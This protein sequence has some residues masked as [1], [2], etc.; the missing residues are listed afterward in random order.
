MSADA[1]YWS[2]TLARL[3]VLNDVV[4]L[5]YTAQDGSTKRWTGRLR[6]LGSDGPYILWQGRPSKLCSWS[7][8]ISVEDGRERG[9]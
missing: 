8:L 1:A 7:K 5:T 2:R 9:A 3:W 4:A 6:S